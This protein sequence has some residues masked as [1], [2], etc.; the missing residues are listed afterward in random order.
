L[1]IKFICSCGKHLRARDD[2]ASRR[3]ICPNCGNPVGI[4]SLQPHHPG[5][6]PAMT[7]AERERHARKRKPAPAETPKPRAPESPEV[8]A[9][10]AETNVVRLLSTRA[11]K[12]RANPT[13]RHL[14]QHW[15]ECLLYPLR[16]RR[17]C[18]G[19]AVLMTALSAGTAVL[20]PQQLA[21]N[22][23]EQRWA[24]ALFYLGGLLPLAFLV[25]LPCAFLDCVLVSA[26]QGEI[27]YIRWSGNPLLTVVVSGTKWL[28]CFLAGPVVFAAT[29]WLYWLNCGEVK[30]LDWL[31][32]AELGVVAVAYQVYALLAVSDRGRLRDLNPPAVADLAHRLGWRTLV[33]VLV[34]SLVLL[35]HGW[36]LTAGVAEVHEEPGKGLTLLVGGWLSGVFW[37][38]FFCRLLGLRC[39]RSR[40]AVAA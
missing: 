38:T 1:T 36:V 12:P 37:G 16:A 32:L 5:G 31:I 2:M 24:V 11:K 7:P 4:P 27:Y 17:L 29:A 39:Y 34:A 25:G 40:P 13:G 23:P 19:L 30:L 18:F 9:P 22:P 21:A 6:L 33:V 14:E 28:A 15:H 8:P 35:A 10:P 26:V 3:S 20:L